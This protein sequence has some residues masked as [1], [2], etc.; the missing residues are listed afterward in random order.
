MAETAAP[1]T[2]SHFNPVRV[3]AGCLDDLLHHVPPCRH[4]LLVTSHG[5]T[6]RGVTARVQT[7]LSGRRVT[8]FDEVRPNPDLKDLDAATAALRPAGIDA[9]VGLGGGSALDAAKAL[10]VTLANPLER[11]L[12]HVLR[13]GASHEW[14]GRL[15]MTAVPTTSGT[16]AEVTPFATV[17]D[18]TD[19][20]KYS[21]AG[22][23]MYPTSALLDA[24]LTLSLPPEETLHTGLDAIS[25]ALESL[26]NH[27]RTPVS[28]IFAMRALS[29]AV[30]ALPGALE[31]PGDIVR[32]RQMQEASLLAG[33]AISQT[34]TA[35]AH[36]VSYPLTS[37][38]GVPHGLACSFTLPILLE[39]NL[40][41]LISDGL[42]ERVLLRVLALL[43]RFDLGERLS[44][45]A[46]PEAVLALQGSMTTKGRSENYACPLPFGIDGLLQRSLS[47]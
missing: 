42:D 18:H 38:F 45:Y 14:V 25:H 46:Q 28:S 10:A 9:V 16:G 26:W 1:S 23:H 21:L 34:R 30:D 11:P 37:H 2:W 7:L 29:L 47:Q 27:H 32:R 12:D 39:A 17:W 36:A 3:S 31:A 19:H 43:Q 13:Q 41:H 5:F 15:P 44:K 4:I 8:V 40:P 6:R 24:S 33:L 20:K 35:I 22:P